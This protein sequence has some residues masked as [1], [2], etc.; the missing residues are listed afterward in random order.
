MGAKGGDA[1]P[2]QR[3]LSRVA[4]IPLWRQLRSDLEDRLASGE[5]SVA[6]PGELELCEQYGVSRHTVREAL[7]AL[8]DNGLVSAARG[9]PPRLGGR[10]EIA[11]PIGAL[12]SLFRSVE[13]A[14][15]S[16]RSLVRTL[17]ARADAHVAIRLGLEESTPL[18]YL[19]RLRL[20]DEEPLAVDCAWLPVAIAE[21]L[22]DADFTHTGLYDELFARCGVRLTGGREQIRAIIPA[23]AHRE[24]LDIGPDTAVMCVER[25]GVSNDTPVEWRRSVIRGDR[26]SVL[27]EFSALAGYQVTVAGPG[28]QSSGPA[29]SLHR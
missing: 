1:A 3:A 10:V 14:N 7:R 17:D 12:Y 18:V 4:G 2:P 25:I 9:R 13:S 5:F 16:Q 22:L 29:S 20:A 21:P 8:R 28:A 23:P 26:F 6:F 11:Q 27:A 24:L 19:E 15:L